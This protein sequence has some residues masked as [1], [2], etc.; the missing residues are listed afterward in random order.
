MADLTLNGF[1]AKTRADSRGKSVP[2]R[3]VQTNG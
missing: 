1:S 3:M 2:G